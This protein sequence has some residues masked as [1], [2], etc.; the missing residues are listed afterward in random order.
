MKIIARIQCDFKEKF[1]I[2]RQSGLVPH[3]RA[4][5]VFEPEYRNADALRGIEE[6]SHLWLIWS[7]SKAERESWSPT[8]RPPR[9]GGNTRVGVFAT[10]S[11][12]RPNAIGLSSVTLEE[13]QLHTPDGPV[14]IVGGADLLDGTPIYDIKPYLPYVDCH[15]DAR[16]GFSQRTADYALRVVFP[17]ALESRIEKEKRQAVRGVLAGDPRPS[18]QHDPERMYG[19][20]YAQYNV[21]FTV[22]GDTLTVMDVLT[23]ES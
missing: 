20:R 11:P 19:V 12:F 23:E 17:E 2:P 10:R 1:G 15:P 13:V 5:I 4:R 18:Y 6:Y 3:T 14:L 16:G 21:K 7:F 8:V 9:L 22:D